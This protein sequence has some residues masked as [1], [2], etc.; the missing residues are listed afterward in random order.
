MLGGSTCAGGQDPD[1]PKESLIIVDDYF[2]LTMLGGSGC[3][4]D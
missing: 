1:L 3:P 4:G 2:L